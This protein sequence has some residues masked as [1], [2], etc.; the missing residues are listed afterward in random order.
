M[1]SAGEGTSAQHAD[2]VPGPTIT[3]GST[4][5]PPANLIDLHADTLPSM[6]GENINGLIATL[7]KLHYCCKFNCC[8]NCL[9]T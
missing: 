8:Y 2:G 7:L 1:T 5:A 3:G 9:F 4:D 6:P